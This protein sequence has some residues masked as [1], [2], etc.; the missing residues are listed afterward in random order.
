MELAARLM[1]EGI[2]TAKT[3]VGARQVI[4]DWLRKD[5][6]ILRRMPASNH[7][8]I[9]EKEMKKIIKAFSPGGSGKFHA[10]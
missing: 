9:S 7:Y 8:V 4:Y 2:I 5:K 3:K 10:K 6:L 1:D